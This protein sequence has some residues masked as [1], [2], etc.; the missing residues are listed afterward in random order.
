MRT[1]FYIEGRLSRFSI[2][3]EMVHTRRSSKNPHRP[4][5]RGWGERAIAI[6]GVADESKGE[7]VVLLSAVDIN[8]DELRTKLRDL[9]VPNLDPKNLLSRNDPYPGFRETG[10]EDVKS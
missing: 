9:G 8:L 1:G 10:W 5:T 7:A 6:A 2:A 3:G 4:R